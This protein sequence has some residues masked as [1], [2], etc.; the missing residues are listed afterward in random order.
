MKR[1]KYTLLSDGSTDQALLPILT[2]SLRA[3][4]VT[5]AVQSAWADL[6]LLP[7]P[8]Q[9]LV[10]RMARAVDLYP[11]DLL[12]V[13]RD[14]EK[15]SLEQR[16][17]QIRVA[18]REASF[19]RQMPRHICVVP[20]RMQEAWLLFDEAAIRWAAGNPNGKQSLQLPALAWLEQLPDPKE[21]LYDLLREASGLEG[22]RR[23]RLEPS[24]L[25][26]RV[27]D[28]IED[29]APLRTL[30]AFQTLQIAIQEAVQNE[31]WL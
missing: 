22:R 17:D 2:W 16:S 11:C 20:V 9:K 1:L 18:F 29:Y 25:A 5:C 8:P 23:R 31:G 24:R 26:V 12:F 3:N 19:Q 30:P 28:F 14:A 15:E 10:N 21:V 27:A 13:H 7:R 6:R 4:H